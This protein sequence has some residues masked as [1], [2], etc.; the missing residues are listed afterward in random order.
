[1]LGRLLVVAIAGLAAWKYRDSLS[2]YVRGNT[3]PA[4]L[5]IAFTAPGNP[6]R[7]S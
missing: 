6:A 2:E 7:G 3:G 4:R 1:M 5:P